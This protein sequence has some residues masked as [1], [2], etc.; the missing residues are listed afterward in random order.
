ML[1]KFLHWDIL[2]FTTPDW[3]VAGFVLVG[4]LLGLFLCLYAVRRKSE[5]K[6]TLIGLIIIWF[7]L[8]ICSYLF[9]TRGPTSLTTLFLSAL[10]SLSPVS[11]FMVI[12]FI[13]THM[14]KK[15]KDD[16]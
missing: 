9:F 1:E 12:G 4:L 8:H 13:L 5:F 15:V 2:I 14:I 7:G 16:D 10:S 11:T 6:D 3:S